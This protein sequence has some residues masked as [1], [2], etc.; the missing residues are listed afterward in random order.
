MDWS[1]KEK[2][3]LNNQK[4]KILDEIRTILDLDWKND[5]ETMKTLW[6]TYPSDTDYKKLYW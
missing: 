5:L 3:L 4:T 1:S 6:F 2:M